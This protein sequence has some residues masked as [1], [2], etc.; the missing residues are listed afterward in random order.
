MN[1]SSTY[2]LFAT[3][4]FLS[5]CGPVVSGVD[6]VNANIALSAAKTAGAEKYS[7]YEYEAAKSY[8]KKAREEYGYSEYR[9][10]KSFA[11]KAVMYAEEARKK[12]GAVEQTEDVQTPC[13]VV[14]P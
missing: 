2:L 9:A 1:K 13:T 7:L 11:A 10:A 6:I 14:V 8:L 12:S 3:L 4:L 5:A